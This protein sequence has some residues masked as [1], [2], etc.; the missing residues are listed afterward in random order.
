[1]IGNLLIS[2][3]AGVAAFVVLVGAV[4]AVPA[5][6]ALQVAIRAVHDELSHDGLVLPPSVDDV[7]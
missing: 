2:L 7:P 5:S 6:G 3:I 4:L 1:M